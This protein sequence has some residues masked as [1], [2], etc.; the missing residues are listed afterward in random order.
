MIHGYTS[1]R[2]SD[3]E[4]WKLVLDEKQTDSQRLGYVDIGSTQDQDEKHQADNIQQ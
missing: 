2:V 4:T 1:A 3:G